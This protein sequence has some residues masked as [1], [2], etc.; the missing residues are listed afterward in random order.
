MRLPVRPNNIYRAVK[1][2]VDFV[3]AVDLKEDLGVELALFEYSRD[4]AVEESY[5][6]DIVC[7]QAARI[8]RDNT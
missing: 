8:I 5:I 3:C 2:S 7:N 4:V 1:E 6:F